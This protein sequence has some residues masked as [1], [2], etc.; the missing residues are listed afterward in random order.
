MAREADIEK[1]VLNKRVSQVPGGPECRMLAPF[2]PPAMPVLRSLS[3]AER[4][5]GGRP[6]SVAIDRPISD[7]DRFD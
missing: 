7:M 2:G 6:I 1:A 5:W 3:G 4:T